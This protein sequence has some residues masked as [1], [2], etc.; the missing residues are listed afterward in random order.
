[1]TPD[2]LRQANVEHFRALLNRTTDPAERGRIERLLREE[3][4]KPASAYPTER[5]SPLD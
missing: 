1:M 3:R 5:P 2:E 4:G